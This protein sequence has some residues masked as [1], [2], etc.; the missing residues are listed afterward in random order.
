ML[1][2]IVMPQSGA[3]EVILSSMMAAAA[4]ATKVDHYFIVFLR[5]VNYCSSYSNCQSFSHLT[6]RCTNQLL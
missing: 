4:K 5:K 2:P 3:K 6:L 1:I